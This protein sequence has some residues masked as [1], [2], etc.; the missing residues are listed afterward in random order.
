MHR[1]GAAFALAQPSMV[2]SS[3]YL[4]AGGAA[5]VVFAIAVAFENCGLLTQK[6]FAWTT[7][8]ELCYLPWRAP[9]EDGT[10]RLSLV[11]A[12]EPFPY[13]L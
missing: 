1:C 12:T 7:D 4:S 6:N 8:Y 5:G 3:C 10:S 11:H 13:P 2:G 9:W